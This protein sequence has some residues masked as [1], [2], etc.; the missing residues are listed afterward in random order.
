M[1]PN[2]VPVSKYVIYGQKSMPSVQDLMDFNQTNYLQ[3]AHPKMKGYSYQTPLIYAD[4]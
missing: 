2:Y 4:N 1:I 3:L